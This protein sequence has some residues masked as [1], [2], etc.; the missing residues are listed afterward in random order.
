MN[1]LLQRESILLSVLN[2]IF[3]PI[4][5]LASSTISGHITGQN[6]IIAGGLE[7]RLLNP[8]A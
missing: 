6:S 1:A 3:Q 5:V 2:T 4:L 7:G 8:P